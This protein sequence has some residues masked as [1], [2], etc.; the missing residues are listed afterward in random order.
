[1]LLPAVQGARE[2]SRCVACANNL[3]QIGIALQHYHADYM[4]FPP[5]YS[6]NET[7]WTDPHWT[8]TVLLLP[9]AEQT[10]LFDNLSITT[11]LFGG[12][13]S[14][15]QPTPATQ[16]R[17]GV[18]VCPSDVGRTLNQRKGQHAKSNYRGIMGSTTSLTTSFDE[19]SNRNG[20]FYLNS[21]VSTAQITDGTSNTLAVGECRL[22]L[23]DTGHVGALWAGMR[24]TSDEPDDDAEGATYVSDTMWWINS[25][26]TWCINGLGVQAF[27]SNHPGGAQFLFADGAVHLINEGIDGTTLERLAARNDGLPVGQY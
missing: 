1:L 2:A 18:F 27:S 11:Q 12:G 3:H 14:L 19:L 22:E 8:W 25:D 23:S 16:T 17:L 21:C 15:A 13:V 20:L 4:A 5:A 10:P 9:Y 24:G 7:D 6:G 26:P